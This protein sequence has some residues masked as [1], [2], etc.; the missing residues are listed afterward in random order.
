[1]RRSFEAQDEDNPN[2]FPEL[3][4]V[5]RDI[6]SKCRSPRE[7][8]PCSAP[9]SRAARFAAFR[10]AAVLF[11]TASSSSALQARAEKIASSSRSRFPR[12]KRRRLALRHSQIVTAG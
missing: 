7:A 11:A 6:L 5:R 2:S 12:S 9:S 8:S 1:E 4:V 10:R 3:Q